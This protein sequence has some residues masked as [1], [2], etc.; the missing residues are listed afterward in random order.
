M[1]D[2][3]ATRHLP[4]EGTYN[5]RELGGYPG[6]D[7]RTTRWRTLLRAD[8]LH[9]LS[10]QAQEQLLQWGLR[11]VIDL[12]RADELHKAPNVFA[13][14]TR[15]A[16]R[17]L[18]LLSDGPSGRTLPRTL[19]DIYRII[20][21]E[22][23]SY[24]RTTLQTLATQD[25]FPAI[26]HCTAGKDR[27]GLL[28]AL[29][30]GLAGVS[31]EVIIEDYAL[32]A[33]YLTGPYLDEARR[34]AELFGFSYDF[35]VQCPPDVMRETLEYVAVRYGGIAGYCRAIGLLDAEMTRLQDLLLM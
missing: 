35:Q 7:G 19:A 5:V 32:S 27:T 25:I 12:R 4:L 3:P 20:L 8:S 21:D 14:S 18:S 34:R 29:L 22:R 31:E 10:P 30:L 11:T 28:S 15:V 9:R 23:Q 2:F 13:T 24:I 26:F 6:R 17:H 33:Q 1:H 16:Y